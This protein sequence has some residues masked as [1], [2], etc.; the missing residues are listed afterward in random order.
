MFLGSSFVFSNGAAILRYSMTQ[1]YSCLFV[2]VLVTPLTS[3]QIYTLGSPPTPSPYRPP[4]KRPW[5]TTRSTFFTRTQSLLQIEVAEHLKP[6]PPPPQALPS[7][8][9]P[10][11]MQTHSPQHHHLPRMMSLT[12]PHGWTTQW[13]HTSQSTCSSHQLLETP[14]PPTTQEKI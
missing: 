7:S 11:S 1:S 10:T 8:A 13:S 6:K 12:P 3:V 5:R 2:V 9:I 14:H 4:F